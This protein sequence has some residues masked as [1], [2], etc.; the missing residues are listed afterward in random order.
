MPVSPRFLSALLCTAASSGLCGVAHAQQP[1]SQSAE[2]ASAYE[3]AQVERNSGRLASARGKLQ[4]CARDECPDFIRSD[5]TTWYAEVQNEVPTL[6][7]AARSQGRD[8]VD[9]RISLGERVLSM[10]ID[11]QVIELDP[12]EYDFEIEAVGMQPLT[13]HSVIVRGERNR[14]IQVELVPLTSALGAD[15][16]P[17]APAPPPPRSLLVPGIFAGIGVAGLAGFGVLAASGKSNESR[18][19]DTCSPS[20]SD[21]QLSSLKTKYLLADVSLGVG[22]ASLAVGAYF[23]FSQ[24]SAPTS[25]RLPAWNVQASERGASFVYGGSF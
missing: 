1:S 5:C 15:L 25:A 9:V 10:R 7:F 23:L 24:P 8:L 19:Q 22:V 18:L 14:L 2:C 21:S 13:V 3:E 20:C 17:S 4:L 12:G 6:V 11:G 16:P